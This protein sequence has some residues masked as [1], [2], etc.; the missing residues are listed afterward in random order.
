[1]KKLILFV[2]LIYSGLTFAQNLEISAGY[3]R[4]TFY[5]LKKENPHYKSDYSGG[6]GS[7]IKLSIERFKIVDSIVPVRFDIAYS[8]YTGH[9][10]I[11]ESG[12]GAGSTKH[13]DIDK[14]VLGI[15]IYPLLFR[16]RKSFRIEL[17]FE[18]DILL[19]DQSTG[20]YQSWQMG[21]QNKTGEISNFDNST[22]TYGILFQ[23][24]YE[25]NFENDWLIYPRYHLYAGG[26]DFEYAKSLRNQFEIGFIRKLGE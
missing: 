10:E 4:N 24:G 3:I 8:H 17:G 19:N 13:T 14:S 15:S 1:M 23:T 21:S 12:L 22:T 7:T 6:N 18:M 25:F 9:A 5:E 20:Y 11:M 2:F 26:K 16:I